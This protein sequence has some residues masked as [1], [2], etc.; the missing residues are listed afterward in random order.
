MRNVALPEHVRPAR[1]CSGKATLDAQ[2][3][4]WQ[5]VMRQ[6]CKGELLDYSFAISKEVGAGDCYVGQIGCMEH[7]SAAPPSGIR[8]VRVSEGGAFALREAV[9][10]ERITAPSRER[11][12]RDWRRKCENS[13]IRRVRICKQIW[14][15]KKSPPSGHTQSGYVRRGGFQC[16]QCDSVAPCRSSGS[17]CGVSCCTAD[18]LTLA[19]ALLGWM[20]GRGCEIG[21]VKRGKGG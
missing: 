11:T 20:W 7:C 1:T 2:S 8:L 12:R 14:T 10:G 5:P 15:Q 4:A 18:H 13:G 6:C 9:A 19:A 21:V 3:S 17:M 16:I